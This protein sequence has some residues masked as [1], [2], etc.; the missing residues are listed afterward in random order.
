MLAILISLT[1]NS[2]TSHNIGGSCTNQNDMSCLIVMFRQFATVPGRYLSP[3]INLLSL[4]A[5][6]IY[7][8]GRL[9]GRLI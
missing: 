3:E 7:T 5:E 8:L 2:F 1:W 4:Y 6:P 9:L